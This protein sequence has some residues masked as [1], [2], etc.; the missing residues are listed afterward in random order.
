MGGGRAGEADQEEADELPLV[1]AWLGKGTVGG[2]GESGLGWGRYLGRYR[3]ADKE[4]EV[5]ELPL[6]SG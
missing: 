2:R 4:K 5:D 1:S 3:A 6:V